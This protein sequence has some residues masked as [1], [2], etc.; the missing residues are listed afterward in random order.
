MIIGRTENKIKI[1]TDDPLGLRA[2]ECACCNP[3]GYDAFIEEE[4]G[5]F[6]KYR[7]AKRT[8]IESASFTDGIHCTDSFPSPRNEQANVIFIYD[9][10]SVECVDAG[11]GGGVTATYGSRVTSGD[12][13]CAGQL[14]CGPYELLYEF[15]GCLMHITGFTTYEGN[16]VEIDMVDRASSS[17]FCFPSSDGSDTVI[18]LEKT[19]KTCTTTFSNYTYNDPECP[20]PFYCCGVLTEQSGTRTFIEELSN[21]PFSAP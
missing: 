18:T 1:K 13:A 7:Y 16:P 14:E 5:G 2:V 21:T 19:K 15:S 12:I 4:G 6:K 20:D 11:V 8:I 3:C 10:Q 9:C 17:F